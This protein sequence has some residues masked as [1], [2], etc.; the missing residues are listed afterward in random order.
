MVLRSAGR[1]LPVVL[2][3]PNDGDQSPAIYLPK[4]ITPDHLNRKTGQ[5]VTI[6]TGDRV[7]CEKM[8]TLTAG[9]LR[10]HEGDNCP[11]LRQRRKIEKADRAVRVSPDEF[12]AIGAESHGL[13]VQRRPFVPADNAE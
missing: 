8:H 3:T 10:R 12:P 1:R 7:F 5:S 2:L 4:T 13:G 11:H 6:L 9:L